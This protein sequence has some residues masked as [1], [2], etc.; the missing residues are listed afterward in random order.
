MPPFLAELKIHHAFGIWRVLERLRLISGKSDV[1]FTTSPKDLIVETSAEYVAS[2][3][4][5]SL[6]CFPKRHAIQPFQATGCEAKTRT[7]AAASPT[8]P[9]G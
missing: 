2:N 1:L 8:R 7:E 3:S 4:L 9:R 5:G 6:K